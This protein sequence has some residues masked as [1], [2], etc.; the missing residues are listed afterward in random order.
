MSFNKHVCYVSVVVDFISLIEVILTNKTRSVLTSGVFD[1][2]LSDYNLI[3]TVMW[4]QCP[5]I[6]PRTVVKRHLNGY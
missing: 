6:C 5:N 2:G 1:L 4:L 3:Y